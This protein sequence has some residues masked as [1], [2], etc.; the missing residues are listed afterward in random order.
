MN[1]VLKTESLDVNLNDVKRHGSFVFCQKEF[2]L[3]S[4][5]CRVLSDDEFTDRAPDMLLCHDDV[6]ERLVLVSDGFETADAAFAC[7]DYNEKRVKEMMSAVE[8]V[9]DVSATQTDA[10]LVPKTLCYDYLYNYF[11][12]AVMDDKV[13]NGASVFVSFVPIASAAVPV[14]RKLIREPKVVI[15]KE[16]RLCDMPVK[17]K[18]WMSDILDVQFDRKQLAVLHVDEEIKKLFLENYGWDD[19]QI[20]IEGYELSY[21]EDEREYC[22]VPFSVSKDVWETF[23]RDHLDDFDIADN[24]HAQ[25]PSYCWLEDK[26]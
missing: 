10:E 14:T 24:H 6:S 18:F 8:D 19:I 1:Y 16:S 7:M 4:L 26:E 11:G 9:A 5:L 17:M 13:I 12:G 25:C 22:A 21:W 3:V 2:P 23:I 20:Q 15:Q